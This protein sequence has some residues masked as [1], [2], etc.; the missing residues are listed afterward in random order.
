MPKSLRKIRACDLRHVPVDEQD[1]PI[2]DWTEQPV[3]S[4]QGPVTIQNLKPG[5]RYAFQVRSLGG[6]GKTD[7]SDSVVIMCT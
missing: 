4:F 3:G 1:V 5:V 6:L 7:W 2:G